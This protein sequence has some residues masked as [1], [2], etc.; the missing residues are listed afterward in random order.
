ADGRVYALE[1][2]PLLYKRLVRNVALNGYAHVAPMQA[3]L[4]A[5]DGTV[6]LY[7]FDAASRNHG[8][9]SL[10]PNER[11]TGEAISVPAICG[12]TL[13]RL[14]DLSEC[15]LIKIDV[16]GM[17]PIVLEEL[18]PLITRRAPYVLFEYRAPRWEA[19]GASIEE[20][21]ARFKNAGYSVYSSR[22]G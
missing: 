14:C 4:C 10:L 19:L 8:V 21:L 3:A 12:A 15:K 1:P 9:S 22:R 16:E 13:S 2:H 5:E 6:A 20:V 11:T 17:E 18:W 7:G